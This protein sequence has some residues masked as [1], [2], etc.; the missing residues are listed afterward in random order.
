L[1]RDSELAYELNSLMFMDMFD[2]WE[3]ARVRNPDLLLTD[4]GSGKSLCEKKVKCV[5]ENGGM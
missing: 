5:F 2:L 1:D 4:F 3:K